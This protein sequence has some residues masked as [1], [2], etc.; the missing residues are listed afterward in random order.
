MRVSRFIL[1]VLGIALLIGALNTVSLQATAPKQGP[2]LLTLQRVGTSS[3]A[4]APMATDVGGVPDEID[5]AL[6]GGDADS[7]DGAGLGVAINQSLP[8]TVTGNGRPVN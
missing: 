7:G 8:G 4:S 5:S 1:S 3:F 2:T 6:N